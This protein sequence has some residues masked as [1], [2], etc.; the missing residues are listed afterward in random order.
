MFFT[1]QILLEATYTGNEVEGFTIVKS[2]SS[3][4]TRVFVS[5]F[6]GHVIVA[7]TGTYNTA[8]WGNNAVYGLFGD[9][10]YK[11]TPRYKRAE[12]VQKL[13]EKNTEQK[14]SRL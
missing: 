6:S 13:A 5:N 4:E 14:L 8:D 2:I 11:Q 1:C 3:N 9:I 12:K 10:G 7:H